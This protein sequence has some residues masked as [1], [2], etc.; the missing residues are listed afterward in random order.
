MFDIAQL[1]P[2][3]ILLKSPAEHPSTEGTLIVAVDDDEY[4][5]PVR[6]PEGMSATSRRA[7]IEKL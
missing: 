7:A 2:N 6:L 1:G 3:F 4:R 5:W